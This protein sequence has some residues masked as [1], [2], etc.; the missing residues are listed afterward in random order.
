MPVYLAVDAVGAR[1]QFTRVSIERRAKSQKPLAYLRALLMLKLNAG[2]KTIRDASDREIERWHEDAKNGQEAAK[3]KLCLWVYLTALHYYHSRARIEPNFTPHDAEE[4]TS[5]FFI[6]FEQSLPRIR[7]VTH[8]TRRMLGQMLRRYIQ[9]EKRHNYREATRPLLDEFAASG[10]A[11]EQSNSPWE[12]WSDSVWDQYQAT[13]L[14][15]KK[16]DL[17]TRTIIEYRIKDMAYAEIAIEIKL[18]EAA[19]RMRVARFYDAVRRRYNSR[20]K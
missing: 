10:F 8:F 1:L 18:S 4:L 16:T 17:I 2:E 7:T 9:Q 11:D 5:Q 13:L 19:L 6:E 15:L 12:C 20:A 3:D 14:E